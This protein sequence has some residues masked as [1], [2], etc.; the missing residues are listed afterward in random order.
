MEKKSMNTIFDFVG[1]TLTIFGF[2]IICLII[3]A[4]LFGDSA[5]GYSTIFAFGTEGLALSTLL[6]FLLTSTIINLFRQMFFGDNIIKNLSIPARTVGMFTSVIVIIVLFVWMF[7]WFPVNDLLPWVLFVICFA[8]SSLG[9]YFVSELKEKATNR[10]MQ[11]AL[12]RM[13]KG[14]K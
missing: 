1:Q 8:I 13:Q 11:E 7:G 6:Q 4:G 2:S 14:E 9:G 10:K 3:F 12:E 5:K